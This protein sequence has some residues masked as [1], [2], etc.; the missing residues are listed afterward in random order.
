AAA[1]PSSGRASPPAHR[2]SLA[3]ALRRR[4]SGRAGYT[5]RHWRSGMTRMR[6]LVALIAALAA[7]LFVSLSA[8]APTP[9]HINRAI[10]LLEA[11]QPVY[12]TGSHSGTEGSFEAGKADAQTY[13]DYISFDMEHAPYDVK[14]LA[15]YM[16][17]LVAG[18]P[19]KSG[20][21]TPPVIGNA[22]VER[23]DA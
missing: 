3:R 2:R 14:G 13:A 17:G 9:K 18:G 6:M 23:V 20:H 15:D 12:Y 22:P 10:E 5:H 21:R 8:Q 4:C 1:R 19:T 16:R 7:L 11:R